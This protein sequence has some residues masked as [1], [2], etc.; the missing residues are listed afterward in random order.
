MLPPDEYR[1][2]FECTGVDVDGRKE[3]LTLRFLSLERR[4]RTY[5][6]FVKK[7]PGFGQLPRID[8]EKLFKGGKKSA[9]DKESQNKIDPSIEHA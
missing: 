8:Q 2:V 4:L 1:A 3:K 9:V 6:T 5:V 7:I